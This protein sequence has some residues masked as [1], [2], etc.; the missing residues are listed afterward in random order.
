VLEKYFYLIF[1][2]AFFR[3][4]SRIKYY[5]QEVPHTEISGIEVLFVKVTILALNVHI[6][7]ALYQLVL[8]LVQ[9]N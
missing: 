2:L 3:V 8:Q 6:I 5:F 4:K 9:G 1:L 7:I